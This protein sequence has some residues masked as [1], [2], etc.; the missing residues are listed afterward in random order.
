MTYRT[1]LTL[2]T[3]NKAQRTTLHAHWQ[4]IFPVDNLHSAE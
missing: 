2:L 4:E 3:T 1:Y